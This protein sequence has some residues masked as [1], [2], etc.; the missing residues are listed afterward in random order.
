MDQS[1]RFVFIISPSQV[2]KSHVDIIFTF[3]GLARGYCI[4]RFY[5]LSNPGLLGRAAFAVP[6]E[7][8]IW[9]PVDWHE[10]T[11]QFCKW[12][13]KWLSSGF[14]PRPP[15]VR[16][17]CIRRN[18]VQQNTLHVSKTPQLLSL[19]CAQLVWSVGNGSDNEVS[20]APH[21]LRA[22]VNLNRL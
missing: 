17:P 11:V 7:S 21:T 14:T 3:V 18:A 10:W 8:W 15:P 12:L 4:S 16:A 19:W 20:L 13:W 1:D 9:W 5:L 6:Q 2:T 22:C